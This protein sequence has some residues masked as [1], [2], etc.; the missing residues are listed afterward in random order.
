MRPSGAG[1]GELTLSKIYIYIGYIMP[2][3]F[4]KSL[5]RG[6]NITIKISFRG[7]LCAWLGKEHLSCDK[8]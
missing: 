5:I 7:C 4:L 1:F 6:P 2:T 3:I 8:L